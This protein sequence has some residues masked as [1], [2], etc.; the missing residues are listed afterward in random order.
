DKRTKRKNREGNFQ[1][2]QEHIHV[3]DTVRHTCPKHF[4]IGKIFPMIEE[5]MNV[6]LVH[7][8][9]IRRQMRNNPPNT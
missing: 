2:M 3:Y 1:D 7:Y 5:I 9:L 8:I 4:E 6:L